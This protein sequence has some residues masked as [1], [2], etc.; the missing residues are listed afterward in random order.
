MT[1]FLNN[2]AFLSIY[3]ISLSHAEITN[4]NIIT[5]NRF[6]QLSTGSSHFEEKYCETYGADYVSIHSHSDM[7]DILDLLKS[8]SKSKVY[9]HAYI[10]VKL[11][12]CHNNKNFNLSWTD[13]TSIN[14]SLIKWCDKYPKDICNKS[15]I[16]LN[17]SDSEGC[18]QNDDD[19][20]MPAV[21]GNPYECNFDHNGI[22]Y[23]EG[24]ISIMIIATIVFLLQCFA[25]KTFCKHLYW[26]K[27][28]FGTGNEPSNAVKISAMLYSVSQFIQWFLILSGYF[29]VFTVC[30]TNSLKSLDADYL[31]IQHPALYV[32]IIIVICLLFF[33][34]LT[35]TFGLLPLHI[36]FRLE[37][38][39]RQEKIIRDALS[40]ST[41][42]MIN[43]VVYFAI[44]AEFIIGIVIV[45]NY[46]SKFA[47]DWITLMFICLWGI[48]DVT[49]HSILL[50]FYLKGLFKCTQ[51]CYQK[52]VNDQV[53]ETTVDITRYSVLFLI[54][55]IIIVIMVNIGIVLSTVAW[56]FEWYRNNSFF[57]N[58]T[59][60]FLAFIIRDISSLIVI[61]FG[62]KFSYHWYKDI[63]CRKCDDKMR[64]YCNRRVEKTNLR[65]FPLI[66]MQQLS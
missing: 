56:K 33:C 62:F 49:I 25:L 38:M 41:H 66:P 18:F 21:C 22:A 8:C 47:M 9:D 19:K 26:K 2:I 52:D 28:D 24:L 39:K 23:K 65:S 7:Q 29:L 14:Y 46:S 57:V 20:G 15:Y 11:K 3:Y 27:Y 30:K 64:S 53:H 44:M 45:M 55:M 5:K 59:I 61:L 10:G 17:L 16:H 48:I 40:S 31:R 6:W 43:Y 60:V 13:G 42:K 32:I 63:F 37:S 35:S 34:F 51:Y 50:Y 36:L 54:Y 12:T 4:C 1:T 58:N